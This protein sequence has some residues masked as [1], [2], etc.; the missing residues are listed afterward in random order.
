[1]EGPN[2]LQT[3]APA[4]FDFMQENAGPSKRSPIGP[5]SPSQRRR[6]V[7]RAYTLADLSPHRLSTQLLTF[8]SNPAGSPYKALNRYLT[9]LRKNYG[10][11]GYLYALEQG[12]KGDLFHFHGIVSMPYTPAFK[13]VRAWNY[14][15]GHFSENSVRDI[16]FVRSHHQAARYCAKYAAKCEQKAHPYRNFTTSRNINDRDCIALTW[17]QYCD[18]Q[19]K[20]TKHYDYCTLSYTSDNEMIKY[21]FDNAKSFL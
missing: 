5:P 10:L 18:L 16:R 14:A 8:Q 13:L 7:C 3:L 6:F 9:G 11:W 19:L 4:V 21:L 15:R 17:R 20:F 1:M 2:Q 12:E